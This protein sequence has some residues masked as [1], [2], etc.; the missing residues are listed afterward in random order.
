MT[1]PP[2][3]WLA[4]AVCIA[5]PIGPGLAALPEAE[6]QIV[7]NV[8]ARRR[9]HFAAGRACAHEALRQ[10]GH[11]L[12][13]LLRADSGAPA[14]PA[15]CVGGIAHCEGRAA[16]VVAAAS[17]WAGLGIDVEPDRPLPD[18]VAGYA[19]TAAERERLSR[20]PGGIAA[21]GLLAFSAKECVHKA[22]HPLRAVF[23]EFD[24]V[25]IDLG[26]GAF[27]LRPQSPA[28]RRALAGLRGEGR[29]HRAGGFVWTLL[30]LA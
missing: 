25:E 6:A 26:A 24:E 16:A 2:R 17:S 5:Q 23:L 12:D 18:D 9:E 29:W 30:A 14:W 15:A 21:G 20:L 4:Q 3:D 8:A 10:L 27:A 7:A 13:V 22:V 28:A 1:L 19:L 11:P